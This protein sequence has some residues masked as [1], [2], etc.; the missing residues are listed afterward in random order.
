MVG[1]FG[2]V[3]GN[4]VSLY[5]KRDVALKVSYYQI[6]ILTIPHDR[7]FFYLVEDFFLFCGR[8]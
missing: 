8:K 4:S 5:S 6:Y 1:T 7:R 3:G 2:M